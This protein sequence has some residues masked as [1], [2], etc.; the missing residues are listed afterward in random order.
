MSQSVSIPEGEVVE[1]PLEPEI[2][3]RHWIALFGG[4]IGAFMAILD[5]QIT[6]SSLKDIQ[7]A[8]SATM[9][10]SSWIST[11]YLVAEMIAIPLSGWLSV[12]LGK[13]RYLTW[14]TVVFTVASLLCSFS[15]NMGSMI[16]F[17]AI[18]GFSG[19]A[20][21]PLAFSLVVHLLPVNKRAVGMALFGVTATFAPSIGPTL[22]GWLTE[23]FS[24]HYIFYINLP[25]A[26]A[27][28]CMVN[29]G[30]DDEPLKLESLLKADWLGIITMAI[31][32][33]CLEVVLEEG[34][35]EEWFSSSFIIT[36]SIIS[37]ISLTYFI[38]NEL[39]HKKPLVNLR[40]LK[41]SQFAM[42]CIAYLILGMALLGSIYVLPMYMIQIQGYNALEIGE[43]LM[44]MGFP[45][46][47]IF[48]LVPKLTQIIKA[49]YLVFFGFSMFGI[50]CFV[51][52]HMSYLFGGDQ[53][54]FSMI[55][56]AIGSPFIMVPLSLVAMEGIQKQEVADA[57]TITNV[58]RNL[59]G[60][61]SIAFIATLLDNKTREH[62]AHIKETLTSVSTDGWYQLNQ[63]AA[64][65][66][67]KGSDPTTAMQQAKASLTLT[68]QR[69][70][71]IMAYNDVFFM[72]SCFLA[73]AAVLMFFVKSN[74]KPDP[75][76]GGAH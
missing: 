9:D 68:M 53:L 2:P 19:G 60:A 66:V 36:L 41:Q 3:R 22:G 67:A 4:L 46:L 27:L 42:S 29:Y 33:G 63:S 11:S 6:N 16:V 13:R 50:S 52:T 44:W 17:R 48:P 20:L 74:G 18:Q 72:M 70:A 7:G 73:F 65:F 28:L 35:R 54:I 51:N 37:V 55:L 61:F 59:G 76:A 15:W 14:T 43:V 47:L 71:A 5:I 30:L 31:G 57:S 64:M 32:L 1:K 69:D 75:M 34:N 10:E 49:K 45:Q 25:P 56:R 58:L 24:W 38:I 23:H 21:I 26:I 62:L 8:L 40:L 12:A 39:Q